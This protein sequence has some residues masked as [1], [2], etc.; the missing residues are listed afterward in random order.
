MIHVA[1]PID[2]FSSW[3]GGIEYI[4]NLIIC[5]NRTNELS[6]ERHIKIT[7]IGED[8]EYSEISNGI[9][10]INSDIEIIHKPDGV[11]MKKVLESI[12]AD[13]CF[14]VFDSV[15]REC[16]IPQIHYIADLQ[17]EYL[18]SFF[19][20]D[21]ILHRRKCNRYILGAAKHILVSSPTVKRDI[22]KFYDL[23][24]V[25]CHVLPCL[26]LS[27]KSY[28]DTSDYDISRYDLPEN[29]Y[30]VSNQFW[31]HK[32]HIT[33]FRAVDHIVNTLHQ[34]VNVVCTG[35]MED[36]RDPF[37]IESLKNYLK[38]KKLNNYIWLL[39]YIPRGEQIEIMKKS[40]GV[41]QPTLFEG[42]AGGFAAQ[43][44]I[45]FGRR[46]IVSDIEI[47]KELE[48]FGR[49]YYF[50]HGNYID[51]ANKILELGKDNTSYSIEMAA[52]IFN[53][54]S[55]KLSDFYCGLMEEVI[56]DEIVG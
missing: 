9:R 33:V 54:H 23:P 39:G 10:Q 41:I 25:N 26:P 3:G 11:Q 18:Q 40:N 16:N 12:K 17:E 8:K 20:F 19:T 45:S 49:V 50:L 51:L 44:A 31:K 13:I 7:A 27:N 42:G 55:E 37:Y 47:N 14:P 24:M 22:E 35:L 48:K 2:P 21:E 56:N 29:Y 36:Y 15:Y 5:L 34:K 1:I 52:R 43:E 32:D 38:E 53:D 4:L 6:K 46:V 30:L 28:W